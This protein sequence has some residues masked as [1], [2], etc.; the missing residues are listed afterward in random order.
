MD[1]VPKTALRGLSLSGLLAVALAL[2]PA[3]VH[4]ALTWSQ[5]YDQTIV[6]TS[7]ETLT[8]SL[9]AL[10]LSGD[11]ASLYGGFIQK[12]QGAGV[13][14]FSLAG[15]PPI[16]T[17]AN[18]FNVTTI[19]PSGTD[20]Q[21][22]AVATDHRG[23][24][25]IGS[26]KGSTSGD[27]ARVI[28]KDGSLSAAQRV[29]ALSDITAT[30]SGFTGERVGGLSVRQDGAQLYL[31][32]SREHPDSAYVERYIIGG[33]DVA[34]T[35]LTLD[36]AFNGTGRFSLR[37]V[38]PTASNLRGLEVDQNGTIFV[39]SLDDDA[40]YRIS[41]D[42]STVTK[43]TVNNAID[44]A[45]FD[46]RVFVTSYDAASSAIFELVSASSLDILDSF[47]AFSMFPRI[48]STGNKPDTGYSGIDIDAQGRIF[49]ADQF[50]FRNEPGDLGPDANSDRILVS[51]PLDL[52]PAAV[53]EPGSLA[54][55][56]MALGA[57]G[58]SRRRNTVPKPA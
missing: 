4:A 54:L 20:H 44:L 51:S 7:S 12:S 45:L 35:S 41:S 16:G 37:T 10:A 34:T 38:F 15:D 53:P 9:R 33:T 21:P 46:S 55:L 31:Y 40:V 48:G 28:I 57:F 13:Q 43:Q 29:I 11:E 32:V 23:L 22:K 6:S 49:L 2:A 47:D 50:Y 1:S 5:V 56:G 26:S 17:A 27:N 8:R 14:H 36:V 19:A 42:L 52:L 24:V 25:Y 18:F 39:T 3:S 30:P 58:W